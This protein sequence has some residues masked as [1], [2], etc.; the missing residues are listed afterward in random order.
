MKL[1]SESIARNGRNYM[2]IPRSKLSA[3]ILYALILLAGTWAPFAQERI[4]WQ[5]RRL[6]S[7]PF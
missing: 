7:N 1:V 6:E 4:G 5:I 3:L 2:R